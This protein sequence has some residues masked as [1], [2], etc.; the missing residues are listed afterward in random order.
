MSNKPLILLTTG[1]YENSDSTGCRRLNN[2]YADAI[3]RN[4]AIPVLSLDN[5]EYAK[6]L[7]ERSDGLFLTGGVDIDPS[8]Y[9]EP[10]HPLCGEID[11]QRDRMELCLINEFCKAKKPILGICRG[12]QLINVYFGGTLWQ[13]I[14]SQLGLSHDECMHDISIAPGTFLH[15]LFGSSH[16]VNSYHHQAVKTPG[17]GLIVSAKSSD[18]VIEGL[19]HSSLPVFSLQCHPERMIG[20]EN[21]MNLIFSSFV[22]RCIKK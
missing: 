2:D 21:D 19:E 1:Y 17:N 9:N 8:H 15:S 11:P 18:N 7:A 12:I 22:K 6:D 16:K 10:L 20:G 13:D 4:G 5:G 14:P 3:A